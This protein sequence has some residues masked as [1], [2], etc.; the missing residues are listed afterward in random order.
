M[1]ELTGSC[2]ACWVSDQLPLF[3][4]GCEP[5]LPLLVELLL[6]DVVPLL[7]GLFG[8][9]GGVGCET[10]LFELLLLDVVPLLP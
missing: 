3:N 4:V 7:L 6:L 2:V 8:V 10:V 1:T 5:V 9:V